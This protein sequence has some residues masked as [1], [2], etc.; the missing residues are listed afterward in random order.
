MS[1]DLIM[2]VD[3]GT[4]NVK[5]ALFD[6]DGNKTFHFERRC[7]ES[8]FNGR[9]EIDPRKWWVAFSIGVNSVEEKMKRH[10][11]A[12]CISSQGPT[13]VLVDENGRLVHKAVSW[14]DNRGAERIHWLRTQG[15]DE[16]TASTTAKL[17]ELAKIVNGRTYLL[18]PSD[19]L[20]LKLT[21]LFVNATF[22]Q[23]GY[24]P[25][26]KEVLEKFELSD[27]FLIP[28]LVEPSKAI[29]RIIRRV[30]KHFRL[31]EETIVVA[32]A[33][34]FAAAL[35]GTGTLRPGIVCDRAGT[36][37]GVTLC[38]DAKIDV[39]GLITTPFFMGNFWKIS[40]VLTSSGKAIE[41][42]A[43]SVARFRSIEELSLSSI[44]R[45]TGVIF[46]P[47]LV[48]ERSPYWNENLRG[49]L[50]GL[51][52]EMNAKSLIVSAAEGVAFAV[53]HIIDE[54]KKAGAKIVTIRT[55]GGQA[56]NELWNQIKADVL[57]MNVEVVQP[58][59]ELLGCAILAASYLI[60]EPFMQI[61]QRLVKVKKH[62]I[63]DEKKNAIYDKLYQ[64]YLELHE[65]NLDLFDK[66]KLCSSDS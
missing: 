56:S 62:F 9:H 48:G 12:I 46:L 6:L 61:A 22:H 16:Q 11:R 23:Y 39:P 37:E 41:W 57:G 43:N 8:T 44:R 28:S 51:G 15:L 55:T 58:D 24:S 54:M 65:R 38:S 14:L 2:T 29:G 7:T 31:P 33:P 60:E 17:L 26:Y 35:I 42:V 21:G 20:I 52:L 27:T 50:F 63:P 10:I 53:K 49:V 19:Y 5:I 18:Q 3:I 32:G 64:I 1:S 4:T 45:P 13:I 66:L 34:D 30:A 59:A 25:W 40:G 36:S 47:H